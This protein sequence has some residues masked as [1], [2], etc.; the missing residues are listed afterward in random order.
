M[1]VIFFRDLV[2]FT[3][4]G[5]EGRAPLS[6]LSQAWNRKATTGREAEKSLLGAEQSALE[7]MGYIQRGRRREV[8]WKWDLEC[9]V[10]TVLN[11]FI[12]SSNRCNRVQQK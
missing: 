4:A 3:I 12:V 7:R 2:T 11:N 6:A 5:K 10:D 1:E 9:L 8:G